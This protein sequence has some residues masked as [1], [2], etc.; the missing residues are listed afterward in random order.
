M[1]WR[2]LGFLER[3]HWT[4][5][6]Q[7]RVKRSNATYFFDCVA[8]AMLR[9][10]K[11]HG[12]TILARDITAIRRSEARFTELFESLQEGIYIVTPEDLILEV[13]P[14]LVRML[15]YESKEALLGKHVSDIF[16]DQEQR[17]SLAHEIDHQSSPQGH[18]IT[19]R[20]KDGQPLLCLNTS[21][22]VRDTTGRIVRYQGAVVDITERRAIEKRLHK[23]QEFARR[24]VDSFPDLIFVVD[25]D[26][27]Y[28]FASPR[29]EEVLGY[30][31]TETIGIDFRRA[32]P[33]GRTRRPPCCSL[34]T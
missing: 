29:V 2:C 14:A 26:K 5:V 34:M 8:H 33:S 16:V 23:E 25:L 20:R 18:E 7:V 3:R 1:P 22:V 24:L 32:H 19:L 12:L 27:R 6:V 21:T 9:D 17:N 10:D 4:G 11:V 15:G 13:N 28:T 31:D 30:E